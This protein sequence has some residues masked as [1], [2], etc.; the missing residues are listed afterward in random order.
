MNHR[1]R[2]EVIFDKQIYRLL[3]FLVSVQS[4]PPD[5][6]IRSNFLSSPPSVQSYTEYSPSG[7]SM[8]EHLFEQRLITEI[9]LHKDMLTEETAEA[10]TTWGLQAD[11]VVVIH[12]VEADDG[13]GG[14]F[15]EQTDQQIS[16]DKSK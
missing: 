8:I 13:A 6:L 3:L 7:S 14:Q 5:L 2:T 4:S 12:T 15:S 11:L 1:R 9:H 16:H 10:F